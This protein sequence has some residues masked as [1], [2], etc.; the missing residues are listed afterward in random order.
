MGHWM[1]EENQKA[2]FDSMAKELG[3]NPSVPDDWYRLK[4]RDIMERGGSG[5]LNYYGGS[6]IKAIMTLY[7]NNDWKLWK[8]TKAPS[9]YWDDENNVLEY[10]QWLAVQL[11]IK[12]LDDWYE[13][14]Y[15]TFKEYHGITVLTRYGGFLKLLTKFFPN[16]SW[17]PNKFTFR[18][19]WNKSQKQ[20][21]DI[22]KELF[23]SENNAQ[24]KDLQENYKHPELL[25]AHS[26]LRMELDIFIPALNLAFEY[27]G[28][29]HYESHFI[30]GDSAEQKARD[31]EKRTACLK[32]GIKLVEIPHWLA[33]SKKSVA[34]TINQQ[35][36]GL[37]PSEVLQSLG[38]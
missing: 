16:H 26:K 30:F 13:A 28:M 15:N 14:S 35:F 1:K 37:L 12:N 29:H 2:F 11:K 34:Q 31:Q 23:F 32:A 21:T 22:A 8:F 10:L 25:H 19:R 36:P 17:D 3:V 9:H 24:A 4:K 20:L 33:L 38:L 18:T 6:Y 5:I 27:H 7:P